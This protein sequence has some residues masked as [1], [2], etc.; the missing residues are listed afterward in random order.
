LRKLEQ[1]TKFGKYIEVGEFIWGLLC[2]ERVAARRF[3]H[4]LAARIFVEY[5]R[6]ADVNAVIGW[7]F[8]E[9]TSILDVM[10]RI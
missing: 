7:Q 6:A 10:R 3:S 1:Y 8:G 9:L 2:A 4:I 5:P